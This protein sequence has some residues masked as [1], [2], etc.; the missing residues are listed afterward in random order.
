[1]QATHIVQVLKPHQLEGVRWLFKA[2]N[3]GGWL[4]ADGPG[5]G[6]RA[7]RQASATDEPELTVAA[8]S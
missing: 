8:L 4:L 5:L 1:M 2:V 7:M 6:S 3:G